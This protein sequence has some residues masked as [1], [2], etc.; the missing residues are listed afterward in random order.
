MD[1]SMGTM[2]LKDTL[3]LFG[4]EG[5]TLSLPLFF[6][7]RRINILC[8]CS[9]TMAKCHFFEK[10]YGTEWPCVHLFI[11]SFIRCVYPEFFGTR[12]GCHVSAVEWV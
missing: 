2:Y 12:V 7:S 4:L 10:P 8:H 1:L 3:V 6:L 5:S 9:S 11:H